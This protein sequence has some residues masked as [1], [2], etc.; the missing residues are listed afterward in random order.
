MCPLAQKTL[1]FSLWSAK[2]YRSKEFPGTVPFRL[3]IRFVT[4]LARHSPQIL[5]LTNCQRGVL[6]GDFRNR[7]ITKD[8]F[9]TIRQLIT[10]DRRRF[11]LQQRLT[12]YFIF[13]Q[14]FPAS[15]SGI[16]DNQLK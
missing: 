6:T 14:L 7:F 16:C 10:I 1:L 3:S 4:I 5:K 12:F 9:H 15:H 8:S 13:K 11:C 2:F